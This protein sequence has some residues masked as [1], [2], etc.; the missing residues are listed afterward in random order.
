LLLAGGDANSRALALGVANKPEPCLPLLPDP[1]AGPLM[2]PNLH[3]HP[4][5]FCDREAAG[6][7][8]IALAWWP[9]PEVNVNNPL[10]PFVAK[11]AINARHIVRRTLCR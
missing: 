10:A 11:Y 1:K 4:H 7:F 3:R 9:L 2:I 8:P 5:N 6:G